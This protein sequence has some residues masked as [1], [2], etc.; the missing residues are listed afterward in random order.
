MTKEEVKERDLL[1]CELLFETGS[2][3]QASKELGI[4]VR[5]G[6]KI[7]KRNQDYLLEMTDAELA[8]MS[9]EAINTLRGSLSEDGEIPKAEVRLKAATEV[10]DRIGASKRNAQ[11]ELQTVATP[12]ILMPA[13][14]PVAI[15]AIAIS[16][17]EE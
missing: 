14:D 10:L 17:E 3:I 15:P 1:F 2:V 9:Y 6:R 12:I 13:K 5:T 16:T 4:P 11:E 7:Q 8:A